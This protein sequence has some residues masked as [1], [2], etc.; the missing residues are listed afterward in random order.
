MQELKGFMAPELLSRIDQTVVY[1]PLGKN[2]MLKIADLYVAELAQRLTEK[3]ITIDV[4]KGVRQEIAERAATEGTGARLVRHIVQ[5][6]LEDPIAA[7]VINEELT[8]GQAIVARKTGG[9]VT[10]T[11]ARQ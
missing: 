3:N 11:P 1:S 6:L 4:S 7:S 9:K 2:E 10:V 5:E 8:D